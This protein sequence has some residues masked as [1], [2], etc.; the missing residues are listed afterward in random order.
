M[1]TE[2]RETG[3]LIGSDKVEGTAIYGPDGYQDRIDRARHDRQ[4]KRQGFLRGV[5]L[6]R[7]SRD[8]R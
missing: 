5:E 1:V 2:A 6:W 8:R 3:S 7:L 4:E